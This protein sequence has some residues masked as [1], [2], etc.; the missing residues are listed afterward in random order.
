MSGHKINFPMNPFLNAPTVPSVT[1]HG[2]AGTATRKYKVVFLNAAGENSTASA[3]VTDATGVD[4]LGVVNFERIAW[5][6]NANATGGAK[7]YRTDAA[8]LA[9]GLIGTVAAGVTSFDD[10]GIV[11][12]GNDPPSASANLG[13]GAAISVIDLHDK[14]IQV[15]VG[16]G[17]TVQMQ[18]SINGTEW[19]SEGA[20]INADGVVAVAPT[21]S[22]MRAKQT[23][24]TG[25]LASTG[26]VVIAGHRIYG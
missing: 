11:G 13:I 5:T 10:T 26:T 21:Y 20:A 22:L 18:G 3:E 17:M 2:T 16:A 23:A 8:T 14:Y 9:K 24:S 6:N 7:I 4:V 15:D 12:D 25:V 1:G 19:V